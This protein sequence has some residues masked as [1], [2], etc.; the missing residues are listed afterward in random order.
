ML[1]PSPF[2]SR[3][4][5]V[6]RAPTTASPM[7]RGVVEEWGIGYSQEGNQA[8]LWSW[9][10]SESPPPSGHPGAQHCYPPLTCSPEHITSTA[11]GVFL[12]PEMSWNP[13]GYFSSK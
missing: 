4:V 6:S 5:F 9:C 1:K 10:N 7:C 8:S 11:Q 13:Q 3:D 2:L 12:L